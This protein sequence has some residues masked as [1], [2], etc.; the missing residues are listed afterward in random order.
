MRGFGLLLL[1]CLAWLGGPPASSAR[2]WLCLPPVFDGGQRVHGMPAASVFWLEPLLRQ[3]ELC[4]R[5]PAAAGE[6]RIMMF[7]SSAVYGLGLPVDRTVGG[8]LNGRFAANHTPAH[9]FNLAQVAPYQV[10]DAVVIHAALRYDPD[11]IL[12]PV[13]LAEFHHHAPVRYRA[14]SRFFAANRRVVD[15][16]AAAPPAGLA[17][18]FERYRAAFEHESTA[19][20]LSGPLRES[21]LFLRASALAAA[22]WVTARFNSPVLPMSLPRKRQTQYS[23][24]KTRQSGALDFHEW[25]QWNILAYLQQLQREHDARVLVVHWPVAH[26]PVGDCYNVRFTRALVAEFVEWLAAE[27]RARGLAHLDL[28]D[29]LTTDEF[30]DSV[31]VS[32]SGHRRI[33]D[34]IAPVLESLLEQRRA[35]APVARSDR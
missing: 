18:P 20:L 14:Q 24:D 21:G 33:A 1:S 29:L 9:L 31:H 11:V 26:E 28:H 23:C 12:Y 15:Q 2:P 4:W 10:R 17:E 34:A 5:S 16:M 27:T 13:T 19:S 30:I 7:G 25:K 6:Q 35:Q 22:Q 32:E 3:H 8:L